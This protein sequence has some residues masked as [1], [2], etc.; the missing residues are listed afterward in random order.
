MNSNP[1]N[2]IKGGRR[3]RGGGRRLSDWNKSSRRYV[4]NVFTL[5][6]VFIV[7]VRVAFIR[8]VANG[9]GKAEIEELEAKKGKI[10][11]EIR[12]ARKQLAEVQCP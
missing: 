4:P 11:G 12:E 6:V 8:V 9:Q 5:P 1:S 7:T 3:W 10:D 2:T